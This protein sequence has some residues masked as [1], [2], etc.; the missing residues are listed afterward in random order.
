VDNLLSAWAVAFTVKTTAKDWTEFARY[1]IDM[2]E[3]EGWDPQVFI[4]WVKKQEG[5]PAFWS[6]KRMEENYPKAFKAL[7]TVD[8]EKE[9]F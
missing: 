8:V 4:D 3:R 5:Y 9:V 6:R 2:Q 1:A 7:H